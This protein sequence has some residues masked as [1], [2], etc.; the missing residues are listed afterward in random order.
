M[1]HHYT[2]KALGR[3]W[4][5]S[6]IH[7]PGGRVSSQSRFGPWPSRTSSN[8]NN[9]I[10]RHRQHIATDAQEPW[11]SSLRILR[12]RPIERLAVLLGLLVFTAFLAYHHDRLH[13][14][15]SAAYHVWNSS[16]KG[17]LRL[18]GGSL[19]PTWSR[20]DWSE[21][22]YISFAT[23]PDDVCD[24]LMLAESLHRLGAKPETVILYA[25]D[26]GQGDSLLSSPSVPLLQ[27]AV[28]LY[29]ARVEA[30]EVLS[31]STKEGGGETKKEDST[32]PQSLT[33]LL[34]FNQTRY[35]RILSLDSDAT[36]LKPM[37]DLFLL[38]A[39]SPV[40]LPRAYWLQDTLSTSIM[41]ASPSAEDFERI[42][43]RVNKGREGEE[44]VDIIEALYGDSCLV[45]P[46]N[47][48]LLLT[49]EMRRE[50]HSAYLGPGDDKWEA[51]RVMGEARYVSFSD[52]PESN[53]T[54][55]EEGPPKCKVTG[56]KG[57]AAGGMNCGDRDVWMGLQ[58][59]FRERREV[60]DAVLEDLACVRASNED[61]AMPSMLFVA[62]NTDCD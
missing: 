55:K 31:S 34:A 13:F 33:K 10:P 21:F 4:T 62:W 30:V 3:A 36:L 41:L 60:S 59:D 44:D 35:K 58:E 6:P 19:I 52:W 28:E 53:K 26:L 22:A 18:G 7:S 43:A 20:V 38:P 61:H 17:R 48:Y 1:S 49:G 2:T 39:E 24:S 45:I 57:E 23:S 50:E 15:D 16:I 42:T 56:S 27:E 29:G 51:M 12:G 14:V 32:W 40:A 47:P 25:A 54:L 46:H 37:D 5:P 11:H 9:N 8:T